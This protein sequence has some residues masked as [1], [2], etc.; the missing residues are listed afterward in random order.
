[1]PKKPVFVERVLL[2]AVLA[3]IS[4]IAL[5]F[6]AHWLKNLYLGNL[7]SY[8]EHFNATTKLNL[9]LIIVSLCTI[10]VVWKE[11]AFTLVE[12][13]IVLIIIGL[14]IA[15][16]SGGISLMQA[17]KLNAVITEV[18][19][20][21][22]AV[23]NFRS[24]YNALP[25]DFGGALAIWGS[26]CGDSSIGTATSCNGNNN[27]RIDTDGLNVGPF[28]D[29][30]F[31]QHLSLAGMLSGNFNGQHITNV[32][33]RAD[34]NVPGSAYSQA[35]GYFAL[36]YPVYSYP[37]KNYF[38]L[39][40]WGSPQGAYNHALMTAME[41]YNI[42]LKMDDGIGDKGKVLTLRG[43]GSLHGVANAC[44]T[45][46]YMST[47]ASYVLTDTGNNC[48]MDFYYIDND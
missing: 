12:L 46:N 11:F 19:E 48:R 23:L 27:G 9:L 41:A 34:T 47:S 33:Q 5:W 35:G 20:K 44:M 40:A 36:N 15:G 26:V 28:E 6:V 24:R 16:I 32:R 14:I 3:S 8:Q 17:A 7:V 10:S 2:K 38:E 21:Q 13:A 29:L 31:W 37:T 1:M 22:T 30:K 45:A 18:R 25:G 39:G 43:G 4:I 42:D